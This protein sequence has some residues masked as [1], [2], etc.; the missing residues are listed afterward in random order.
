MENM[1]ITYV[2]FSIPS[3]IEVSYDE[4]P[5]WVRKK[6][7]KRQFNLEYP[8]TR[9]MSLFEDNE[10]K[11]VDLLPAFRREYNPGLYF[12]VDPHWT[13]AGHVLAATHLLP[14][15]EQLIRR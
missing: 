4:W 10:V 14:E 12:P 9:L 1:G 6:S 5:D 7:K 11:Y 15:L 2:P 13:N 3:T 8:T